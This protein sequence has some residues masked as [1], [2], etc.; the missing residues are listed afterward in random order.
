VTAIP[1]GT[2]NSPSSRPTRLDCPVC[3]GATEPAGERWGAFSRQTYILRRCPECGLSFVS[4]P[5]TEYERIYSRD[6]YAGKG[7]DPHVD[8]EFELEFPALTVR[9]YEWSGILKVVSLLKPLTAKS[10]WLDFGCG[11]GGLVRHLNE[12]GHCKATG[13][14]EGAIRDKAARVGIPIVDRAGLE[15]LSGTFDVVTAIEVLEHVAEPVREL[16]LVRELLRPGGLLFLTTG[17]AEPFRGRLQKWRYASV[18]EVH[19]RFFEPQTVARA[20]E[21]AGLTPDF[22]GFIPGFEQIIR[23]KVLK[24]LGVRKVGALERLVPWRPLAALV[25]LRYRVTAHPVAWKRAA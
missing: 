8:Y 22:R 10:R 17:N 13:F 3:G 23:F 7:A 15:R 12:G 2:L 14:E 5:W 6:Y 24:N 21:R 11:S 4:N 19:I 9:R 1:A 20:I 18:P 16:E 25:D